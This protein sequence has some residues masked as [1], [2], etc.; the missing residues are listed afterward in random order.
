M[1]L[2]PPAAATPARLRPTLH[3]A[4][5]PATAATQQDSN[6]GGHMS[7][8]RGRVVHTPDARFPYKV[9]LSHHGSAD[10]ARAF[11]TMREAEAFIRRNTPVPA[12][13]STLYDL[14]AD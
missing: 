9:V 8:L 11:D 5:E 6:E 13:H 7:S 2:R 4:A 10:S 3:L 12:P 14:A 1:P